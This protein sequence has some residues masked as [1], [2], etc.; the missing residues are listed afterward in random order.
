MSLKLFLK[1]KLEKVLNLYDNELYLVGG[2][3]RDLLLNKDCYDYDF[4]M[5][6]NA[7]ETARNLANITKGAF[8][9]L[10]EER[11][12]GR[13][14]WNKKR[15]D[16]DLV[17]DFSKIVNLELEN[18]LSLRDLTINSLSIKLTNDFIHII[19]ANNISIEKKFI[20]DFTNGY[21]DLNNK[22][23]RTYK[24]AN[25]INDPLRMLRV[26]RFSNK[27]NFKIEE[28]T[29]SYIKNNYQLIENISKERVL[30]ELYDIFKNNS[31]KTIKQMIDTNLF[32]FLFEEFSSYQE[33]FDS[34]FEKVFLFENFKFSEEFKYK[35]EILSYLEEK[36]ILDRTNFALLK[37]TLLFFYIRNQ[38]LETYLPNL[39]NFMKKFTF[40]SE[41]I[42]SVIK[43]LE[44]LEEN[45][46]IFKQELTRENLYYYF[47]GLKENIILN[48]LLYLVID[49]LKCLDKFEA[50]L[51]FY[52]EDKVLSEQP[53]I[54]DG[55]DITKEFN[56]SGKKI[57]LILEE[58]KKAQAEKIIYNYS[59]AINFIKKMV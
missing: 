24:E 43:N 35:K 41:E 26:F 55:N 4:V 13:V 7:I 17:F 54:I 39:T 48:L 33:D 44:Y 19:T 47:K 5:K 15:N 58:I 28:K 27:Y 2:C 25:L 32:I 8:V 3:I 10:D 42:K 53:K 31:S 6:D 20:I 37:F 36:I 1:D 59:D 34:F 18:D 57:G 38:K 11:D 30:K 12:I 23:V 51:T 45:K 14:V 29:L 40:G 56:I 22:I 46:N 9:L 21:E 49:E 16:I 50:I 52:F